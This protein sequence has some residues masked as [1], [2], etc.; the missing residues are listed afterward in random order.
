MHDA[1]ALAILA[2]THAGYPGHQCERAVQ[3]HRTGMMPVR[4]IEMSS[5]SKHMVH[6]C[7][8]NNQECPWWCKNARTLCNCALTHRRQWEL[9][10]HPHHQEGRRHSARI[11]PR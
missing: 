5:L 4:F 3:Y 8:F 10:G 7:G 11:L 9:G 2:I 6:L 1:S